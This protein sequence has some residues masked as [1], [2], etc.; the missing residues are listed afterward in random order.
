AITHHPIGHLRSCYK[1]RNGT[2]R[3]GV[4]VALARS[5]LQIPNSII[6]A[7][8]NIYTHTE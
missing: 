4:C 3:Q 5:V 2:P 7:E 8:V 6:N 1:T